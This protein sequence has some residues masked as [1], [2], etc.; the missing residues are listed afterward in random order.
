MSDKKTICPNCDSEDVK[1]VTK[2]SKE[3]GSKRVRISD[4][5]QKCKH[6]FNEIITSKKDQNKY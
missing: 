5:C 4:V 2:G 6:I 3:L 1:H